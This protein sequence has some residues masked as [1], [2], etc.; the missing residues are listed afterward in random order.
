MDD[1]ELDRLVVLT[2]TR[3]R[4]LDNRAADA[5]AVLTRGKETQAQISSLTSTIEEMDKVT[6]LLN[7]MGEERQLKAQSTIEQLV[8]QGL[9]T[10]FDDTLSFH[11]V[12][13]V[14]GKSANVEFIVRTTLDNMVIE[15][16]VMEAR[17]G[18]MA[19]TI[20]FLLRIVVM[21]LGKEP[22]SENVL[23]LD[24]TFAHVSAEYLEGVGNFLREVVDK[25]GVQIIMV[26]H[27]DEFVEYADKV[28]RF[29]AV[30]G[31]TQ[32]QEN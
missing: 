16:P 15:T 28:Y 13:S 19:A 9:H 10:I 20:G 32:V 2:R 23:I 30:D 3:R 5:R 1:S 17:G 26:T 7:S 18:G 31:K 14:R 12:Q 25:T 4:E 6:V 29:S 27:Q 21:L 11:I 24:E 8:T 22:S